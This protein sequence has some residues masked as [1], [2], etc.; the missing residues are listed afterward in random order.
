[1]KNFFLITFLCYI[2]LYSQNKIGYDKIE[3][4]SENGYAKVSKNKK[5]YYID[6][7]GKEYSP[8]EFLLKI[9]TTKDSIFIS[10]LKFKKYGLNNELDKNSFNKL[11]NNKNE[12]IFDKEN[13]IIRNFNNLLYSHD[14]NKLGDNVNITAIIFNSKGERLSQDIK[15][16]SSYESITPINQ[17]IYLHTYKPN[18]SGYG[19][20]KTPFAYLK[21]IN[22]NSILHKD[23]NYVSVSKNKAIK[24]SK[25]INNELKWGFLDEM[26]DILIDF[27]F[28]K[29]PSDFSENLAVVTM[30][31]NN[32][33]YINKNGELV[34]NPIYEYA[35]VFKNGYAIVKSK[36]KYE[37]RKLDNGFKIINMNGEVIYNFKSFKVLK[38]NSYNHKKFNKFQIEDGNILRLKEGNLNYIF[39]IDTKDKI[40]TKY[41]SIYEFNCGLSKFYGGTITMPI[42]G[43]INKEG[44]I[45]FTKENPKAQF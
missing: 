24:T 5:D 27:K 12:I 25:F 8:S 10:N 14:G 35:S 11:I 22:D 2:N 31:D 18:N 17:N 30:S 42:E 13:Q 39:N 9:N 41:K 44:N 7:N 20:V 4:F 36:S 45:I 16:T 21:K 3:S 32:C 37:N 43:Y 29:E 15:L 40:Q 1:M 23:I 33:G 26:G 38:R 19:K 28:S 6:T 34:I